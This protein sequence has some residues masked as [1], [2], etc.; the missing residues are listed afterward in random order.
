VG[1]VVET[2][3]PL[4]GIRILPDRPHRVINEGRHRLRYVVCASPGL[5]PTVDRREA[6]APR[7]SRDA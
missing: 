1:D 2:L 5:D 7:R 6:H 4:K 3:E